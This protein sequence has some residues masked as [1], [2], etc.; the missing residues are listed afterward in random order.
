M[1]IVNV[2]VIEGAFSD[3]Q[4]HAMIDEITN[5]IV[6]IGGDGIR[7]AVHVL[8]EEIT[9]GMWGIGG[10]RLTKEEIEERRRQRAARGT[11]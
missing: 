7:P 1:P 4:K 10:N 3:A 11:T 5:A 2:K 6:K 8:V 9:S